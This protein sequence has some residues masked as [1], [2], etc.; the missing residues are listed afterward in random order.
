MTERDS[1]SGVDD[2]PAW[3]EVPRGEGYPPLESPP[4]R[5]S[6][7]IGR[8]RAGGGAR[9]LG[10]LPSSV[11]FFSILLSLLLRGED[12]VGL[13][14][15]LL[16]H[17]ISPHSRLVGV[18]DCRQ[19]VRE[20]SSCGDRPIVSAEHMT[21]VVD[22]SH[23]SGWRV[24]PTSTTS[25]CMSLVPIPVDTLA[26]I[27]VTGIPTSA[28]YSAYWGRTNRERYRSLSESFNVGFLGVFGAYFLSFILGQFA[29]LLAGFVSVFWFII[30]PEMKAY[31]RNWELRGG[32]DLVDPWLDDVE[33]W[34][35]LAED[36]RGLYGA[37]YLGRVVHTAV[38]ED[39]TLPP[40]E[41]YP[42][43]DFADYTM[44]TDDMESITGLPWK[45]RLRVS[46]SE[47]RELQV[48]ARMS[49]EYLDILPG[50]PV[51]AVLLSTSRDFVQLAGMT[52]I[53]VPDAECWVGDYPYLDRSMFEMEIAEPEVWDLLQDEAGKDY[54]EVVESGYG[55]YDGSSSEM[56]DSYAEYSYYGDDER[57]D[58]NVENE[59]P[60]DELWPQP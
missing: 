45:F 7:R 5:Q 19:R 49:E 42:P 12:G 56:E 32:R 57:S 18:R 1:E 15:A 54:L 52:D 13:T 59:R 51:A 48:H 11:A 29:A 35:N 44:E 58:D 30:S 3:L 55:D 33:E 34:G 8:R 9:R 46:D 38:V 41:E 26:R 50:M 2:D 17:S 21:G 22:T 28:Q 24:T 4:P 31:Q 6:K 23:P 14:Q 10:P 25:L 39:P 27:L 43:E 16:S 36:Q 47:G 37:Y 53:C 20:I 60:K 40:D